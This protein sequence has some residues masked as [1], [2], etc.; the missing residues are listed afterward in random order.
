MA[1]GEGGEL[2]GGGSGSAIIF[3]VVA[4]FVT[5]RGGAGAGFLAKLFLSN[6]KRIPS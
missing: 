5:S 1:A 6:T 2:S 3:V 4:I